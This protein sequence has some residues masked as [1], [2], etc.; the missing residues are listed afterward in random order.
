V[1]RSPSL[2]HRYDE[3][4]SLDP[5]FL[6]APSLPK[7]ASADV[8]AAVKKQREDH[9]HQVEVARET[10]NWTALLAGDAQ[11]TKFVLRPLPGEVHR[12]IVDLAMSGAVGPTTTNH[13][14][15][16]AALIDI[17]NFGD[18]TKVKLAV[19]P[20]YPELGPIATSDIPN[21]LDALDLRIVNQ[22]ADVVFQR[23]E[24]PSPK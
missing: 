5:A 23:A 9:A 22:I 17:V 10:G 13:L 18:V 6:Q 7:D 14:Y 15:L 19:D 3:F 21:A 16:R 1:F 20:K 4:C 12:R 11:P 8:T 24:N 2:Q